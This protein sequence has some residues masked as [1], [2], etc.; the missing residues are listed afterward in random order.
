MNLPTRGLTDLVRDM[1]ASITAS[2]GRLIDVSAG[3]VLRA[4]IE[5]NAAISLW[6]QWLILLTSASGIVTF[7]RYS[8]ISATFVPSGTEVKTQDGYISFMVTADP[9]SSAWQA[10]L[11]AYSLSNGVLSMDLPIAASIAGSLGNVLPN[12]ITLLASAVTGI[13]FVNNPNASTG[14]EDPESDIAFR[15]RFANFFA[16][17]SRATSDAIGYAISLVQSDLRYV[18]RENVDATGDV[19]PG[20]VLIIVDDGSGLLGDALFQSLSTAIAAVRPIGTTISIQ[21]P[22]VVQVEVGL[23]MQ[24]PPELS[25]SEIELQLRS[26]IE[27]YVNKLPIGGTLSVTR[28]SQQA[29]QAEPDIVNISNVTLNGLAADLVAGPAEA[30]KCHSVVFN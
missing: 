24:Y 3:S 11:N 21:P 12:T 30:F 19:R 6:I 15:I 14:G 9:A 26:L 23:S 10:D 8:A 18:I 20:N 2:A 7:S 5:A 16:A 28:I 17:R 1:S 4:V 27:D 13:D 29:Y 22:R 25:I